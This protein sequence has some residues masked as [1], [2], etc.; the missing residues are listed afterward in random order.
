MVRKKWTE[1]DINFIKKNYGV[2]P[3]KQMVPTTVHA[4]DIL[5]LAGLMAAKLFN[6]GLLLGHTHPARHSLHNGHQSVCR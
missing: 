4:R 3:L 6:Q 1:E 5:L 2:I